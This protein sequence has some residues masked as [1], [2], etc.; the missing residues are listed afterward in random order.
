VFRSWKTARLEREL[1]R[2]KEER[3]WQRG[4][5][6]KKQPV[7]GKKEQKPKQHQSVFNQARIKERG[8]RDT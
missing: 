6:R 7:K 4:R 5:R 2:I 3:D 1:Q 8:N